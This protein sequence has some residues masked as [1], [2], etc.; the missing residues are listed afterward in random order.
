ME[1][2][3]NKRLTIRFILNDGTEETLKSVLCYVY[4]YHNNKMEVGFSDGY[5]KTYNMKNVIKMEIE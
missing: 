4:G 1:V 2:T 3:A 5:V